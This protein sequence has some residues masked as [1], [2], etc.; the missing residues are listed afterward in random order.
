[1]NE[2]AKFAKNTLFLVISYLIGFA[3]N[4]LLMVI[5]A[6][7]L[8]A[9]DFGKFSLAISFSGIFAALSD[10]GL[11]TLAI[12]DLARNR[13]LIDKYVGNILS[14]KLALSFVTFLLIYITAN[15][16][17]YQGDAKSLIYIISISIILASFINF[18]SSVFLGL[19]K[20][21]YDTTLKFI[22][23]L[24]LF[25]AVLPILYLKYGVISV[26][27]AW[28]V[29]RVIALLTSGYIYRRDGRS[30]RLE[31]DFK[32][33]KRLIVDS[34]YFGL[35]AL[36]SLIYV[37]IDVLMLSKFRD[38]AE[39]GYYQAAVRLIIL[40]MFFVD[41]V[42]NTSLPML[43]RRLKESKAIFDELVL[44]F[45]KVSFAIVMP[46][47]S[48]AFFLPIRSLNLPMG[49]NIRLRLRFCN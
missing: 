44:A 32:F 18:I 17:G 9:N 22:Q 25:V 15:L 43:S 31:V 2:A 36:L 5:I 34:F 41:A 8:G 19:E 48:F 16:M 27:I 35:Y 6:R 39:V 33:W 26:A 21:E 23:N 13:N 38:H 3:T 40:S 29:S 47:L 30:L 42:I 37:Q 49:V 11:R 10:F 28:T 24:L 7:K 12:R 4:A 20:M 1:M 45:N 14:L 46:I